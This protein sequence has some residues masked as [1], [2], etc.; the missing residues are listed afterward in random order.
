[1]QIRNILNANSAKTKCDANAEAS[2]TR[3][4]E[5]VQADHDLKVALADIVLHTIDTCQI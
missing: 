1:M 2:L 3:C 5:A 4:M